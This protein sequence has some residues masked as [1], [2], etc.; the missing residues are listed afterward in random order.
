[1]TVRLSSL[2]GDLAIE[3]PGADPEVSGISEDSR[4]IQP[5]MVFV[6][7]PGSA[8]DGHAYISD[9]VA[10]WIGSACQISS[11]TNG[12]NGCSRRIV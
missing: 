8:L 6:A 4:R 7:V 2:A 5:G 3:P 12:M 1:M 11:V 9:A 10:R